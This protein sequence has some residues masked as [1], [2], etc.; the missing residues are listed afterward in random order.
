ME[1][2]SESLK[3][4]PQGHKEQFDFFLETKLILGDKRLR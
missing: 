1:N 4:L 3:L 2:A